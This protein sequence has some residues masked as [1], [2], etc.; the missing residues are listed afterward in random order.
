MTDRVLCQQLDHTVEYTIMDLYQKYDTA[1]PRY[2]SYPAVPN[3]SSSTPTSHQWF[4]AVNQ[5]LHQDREI[6]LYIHLPFCESLCTYCAC[7]KRITKNH[8]LESPYI[9]AILAEWN[10]YLDQFEVKPIIRELHLGGGTPTFF[11]PHEL[12]RLLSGITVGAEVAESC[13]FAFEA[14]PNST[15]EEHLRVLFKHGFRRISIG[16]QDIS[17]R[18]LKAINRHQTVDQIRELTDLAR[19]IGYQS[20][21]YDIIYG[22][23]FQTGEDIDQTVAFINTMR[24]DRIAFYSYA[25]VPWKSKGQR[26]FTEEDLLQ[27]KDKLSL[28]KRGE[29]KLLVAG[30]KAIGM[31]H[32]ALPTDS[33]WTSKTNGTLHRNFMGY[34][35]YKTQ[36][37]IGL[38]NSSISDCGEMYIQNEKNVEEYQRLVKLGQLPILKGHEL[39]YQEKRIR[40][41][42]L[43]LICH[44]S[45][46]LEANVTDQ[47]MMSNAMNNLMKMQ[48][49]GLLSVDSHSISVLKKGFPFVRNIC[50]AIDP[51]VQDIASAPQFSKSL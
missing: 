45:T 26:A 37:L 27:G 30:Y 31:D 6:S 36:C 33:L 51:Y 19:K 3:W 11:S 49:D 28:K 23:P 46:Q 10:I 39:T 5:Q 24:P 35:E 32:F 40:Q 43:Q 21:N 25:H 34:T 12:D 4:H 9:H 2:T 16:V 17:E 20:V 22:L 15:T 8:K 50:A 41:H 42:I 38:G 7:N 29:K 1:V 18:I 47:T 48:L 13:N 14:H 44:H